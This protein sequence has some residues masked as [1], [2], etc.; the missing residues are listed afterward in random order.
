MVRTIIQRRLDINHWIASDNAAFQ[1]LFNTFHD[2]W[3]IFLRNHA[4]LDLV[5]KFKAL[6]SFV[7]L[8]AH[9]DVTVLTATTRLLGVL[10]L[11]FSLALD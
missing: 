3:A 11:N 5:D 1:G 4:A 2:S 7:W 10:A 8:K 6:A 9:P